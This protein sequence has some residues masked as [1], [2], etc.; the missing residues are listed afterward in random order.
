M[1]RI[2]ILV[3]SY[4]FFINWYLIAN[5]G[6]TA[7][8]K[9]LSD[10][11]AGKPLL[12]SAHQEHEKF[13]QYR[14]V[15]DSFSENQ[16]D[17]LSNASPVSLAKLFRLACFYSDYPLAAELLHLWKKS[18]KLSGGEEPGELDFYQGLLNFQ[19]GL[20]QSA[21]ALPRSPVPPHAAA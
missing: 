14:K 11:N 5:V 16:N 19:R 20:T 18:A 1:S 9:P 8:I 3:I 13:K 17:E 6:A 4:S 10:S 7:E 12:L 21:A 2:A 15:K